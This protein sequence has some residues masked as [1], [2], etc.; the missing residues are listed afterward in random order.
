M[1]GKCFRG[2]ACTFIHDTEARAK[3]KQESRDAVVSGSEKPDK[4]RAAKRLKAERD[5]M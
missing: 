4:K 2:K 3:A 1:K 5:A